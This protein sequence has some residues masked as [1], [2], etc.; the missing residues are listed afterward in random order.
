MNKKFSAQM[1]FEE[2]K[3]YLIRNFFKCNILILKPGYSE[4]YEDCQKRKS[5]VRI[6]PKAIL[7]VRSI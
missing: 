4:T 1:V 7:K 2:T 6:C 3:N 5:N